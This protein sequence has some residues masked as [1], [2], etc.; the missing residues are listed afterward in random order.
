M[1]INCVAV[2]VLGFG[3]LAH[4][5]LLGFLSASSIMDAATNYTG[6]YSVGLLGITITAVIVIQISIEIDYRR[7][8]KNVTK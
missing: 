3:Y 5:K 8:H 2:I 6:L 7:T 1:F 4:E